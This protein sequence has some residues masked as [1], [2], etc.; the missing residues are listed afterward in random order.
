MTTTLAGAERALADI[1][2]VTDWLI[3]RADVDTTQV[4][5]AGTSRGGILTIA[6]LSERPDVYRGGINFVGGWLGEGCPES[7]A[8][9]QTL[10]ERGSGFGGESLWIYADNDSFYSTAHSR[11]NYDAFTQAGGVGDFLI[12]TRAA[13][14]NG[15]FII[16]DAEVWGGAVDAYLGDL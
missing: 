10:F 9:N 3:M 8:V 11:A 15:H 7:T 14:L 1:D 12:F 6:F 4:I 5:L 2:A 13:G 16:N